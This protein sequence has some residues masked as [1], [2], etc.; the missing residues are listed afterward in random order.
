MIIT[1]LLIIILIIMIM[2]IILLL[3]QIILNSS[4]LGDDVS[5]LVAGR[6]GVSA[7]CAESRKL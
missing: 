1:I 5:F 3:I 7:R 2:I 4:R 6:S